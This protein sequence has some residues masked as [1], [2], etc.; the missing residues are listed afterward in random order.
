MKRKKIQK[1][2]KKY[3]KTKLGKSL[4]ILVQNKLK[5]LNSKER[6]IIFLFIYIGQ[7]NL[8]LIFN[9]KELKEILKEENIDRK[10]KA[11][12]ELAKNMIEIINK[13]KNINILFTRKIFSYVYSFELYLYDLIIL[14][15]NKY[16][17]LLEKNISKTK[18]KIIR[19]QNFKENENNNIYLENN[20]ILDNIYLSEKINLITK[21][22]KK[23]FDLISLLQTK[24]FM[25]KEYVLKL[26]NDYKEKNIPA[27]KVSKQKY[28]FNDFLHYMG[29]IKFYRNAVSHGDFLFVNK[30]E[31]NKLFKF[32]IKQEERLKNKVADELIISLQ[33]ELNIILKD[34][35]NQVIL[36]IFDKFIKYD[37]N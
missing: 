1:E 37:I 5:I 6:E 4:N 22:Y 3:K 31:I 28:I 33:K 9:I 30:T 21:F 8:N 34:E 25:H 32:L 11:D 14:T 24:E 26:K 17:I 12:E 10:Y 29:E 35:K 19:K 18:A 13:L 2:L 27:A 15:S 36:D 16:Q 20:I 23:G 7:L